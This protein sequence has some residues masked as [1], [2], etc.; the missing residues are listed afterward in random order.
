MGCTHA[1]ISSPVMTATTPSRALAAL[2]SIEVM[3]AWGWTLR[4]KAAYTIPGNDTSS[5][6]RPCPVRSRGSST[7]LTGV[8]TRRSTMFV[9][10]EYAFAGFA[11]HAGGGEQDAVDNALVAGA[12]AQVARQLLPHLGF[13]GSRVVSQQ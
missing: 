4:R 11:S 10:R 3:R 2:V 7:R 12:P 9:R 6:K 8:P 13:G 5:A 1:F